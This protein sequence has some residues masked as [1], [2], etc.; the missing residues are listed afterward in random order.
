MRRTSLRLWRGQ[1]H[2]QALSSR[3]IWRALRHD[4]FSNA[5]R[6]GVSGSILRPLTRQLHHNRDLTRNQ[7]GK[8]DD[9]AVGKFAD[10]IVLDPKATAVLAA[11]HSLSQSI[12]DVLF[13]LALLGDDRCIMATYIAGQKRYENETILTHG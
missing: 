1:R 13:A 12:E 6:D 11:R 4:V 3:T 8:P 9:L 10:I 2:S 7:A 5:V